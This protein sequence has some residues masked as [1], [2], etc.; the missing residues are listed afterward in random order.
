MSVTAIVLAAGAS[1][2]FAARTKKPFIN[3]AGKP[4][5]VHSLT[6]LN[7]S[8]KINNIILVVPA[9]QIQSVEQNIVRK[10]RLTKVIKVIAGGKERYDSVWN[11]LQ[12]LQNPKSE[13]RNPNLVLIHDGVR[14]FI[15]EQMIRDT[16]NSARHSGAASIATKITDSV[17]LA[18]SDLVIKKT[19]PRDNLWCVQTPQVFK[20]SLLFNAYQQ[21]RKKR[22]QTTDDAGI[23]EYFGIPVTLVP[24]SFT[25]IKI[26]TKPDIILA[27][28]ILKHC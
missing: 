9:E 11:G 19:V 14:P 8:R 20:F 6:V 24:G 5:L 28:A 4:V 23:L 13:I 15:T 17:K 12:I 10:Y 21:A 3:L 1:T 2:R 22:V 27:E 25:N 16:V 18:E 7:Q 26:T